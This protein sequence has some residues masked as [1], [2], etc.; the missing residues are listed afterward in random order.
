MNIT[1]EDTDSFDGCVASFVN[2]STLFYE[3]SYQ[4]DPS[5]LEFDEN[6]G[7]SKDRN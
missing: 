2:V 4:G 7:T 5:S 1:I 3:D 6:V